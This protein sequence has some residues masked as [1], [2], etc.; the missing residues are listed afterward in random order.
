[1]L[2]GGSFGLIH[3]NFIPA[4]TRA[5]HRTRRGR[6]IRQAADR[7]RGLDWLRLSLI[8]EARYSPAVLVR[9]RPSRA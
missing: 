9:Y 5:P 2:E 3:G 1:M 7:A 4:T 6:R 8:A